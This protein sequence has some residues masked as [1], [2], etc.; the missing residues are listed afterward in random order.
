MRKLNILF[1]V[2]GGR[3]PGKE[4]G[5]GHIFRSMHLAHHFKKHNILFLLE[6]YGGSKKNII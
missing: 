4:L 2:S 1:R 5:N 3:A 6:D